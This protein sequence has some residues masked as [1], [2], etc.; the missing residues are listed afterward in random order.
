[1]EYI[2]KL[3][4]NE[5]INL[6]IL[7]VDINSDNS[8]IFDVIINKLNLDNIKLGKRTRLIIIVDEY[9]QNNEI[10]DNNFNLI[11]E[12][13]NDIICDIIPFSCKQVLTMD[14]LL[15]MH[16]GHMLQ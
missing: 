7:V 2:D 16:N 4:T 15:I 13:F 3:N 14:K 10:H 6:I 11:K 5:D 12:H 8:N 9:L 1:M